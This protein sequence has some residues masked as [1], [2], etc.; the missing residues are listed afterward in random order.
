MNSAVRIIGDV[1]DERLITKRRRDAIGTGFLVSVRSAAIEGVRYSYVVTAHHVLENQTK[2]EVAA[3]DPFKMGVLQAPVEVRHW[4]QPLPK[5]DLAIAGFGGVLDGGWAGLELERNVLPS[6]ILPPLGSVVHFIGL[7]APLDRPMARSG[8]IGALNQVGVVVDADYEYPAH[9]VDCRSYD[10][11]SGSPC[12]V[13]F[14]TPILEESKLPLPMPTG[15]DPDLPRGSIEYHAL[16]C[17]VFNEHLTD[18]S[19]EVSRYGV[20]IVLPSRAIWSAL[21]TEENQRIRQELDEEAI[22]R[23][24]NREPRTRRASV[25]QGSPEFVRFQDLTRKLVNTPKPKGDEE[26]EAPQ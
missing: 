5:V 8:T 14:A 13:V 10:G 2:I 15:V 12:F 4:V 19:P 20:G 24:K 21:M 18:K 1:P 9:L 3:P 23:D 11:F 17:G 16:V 26:R 25:G 22:E 6:N 7:L